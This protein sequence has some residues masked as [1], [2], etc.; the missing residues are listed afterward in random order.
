MGKDKPD[1]SEDFSESTRIG[2][3]ITVA[4]IVIFLIAAIA[5]CLVRI[6][7]MDKVSPHVRESMT[8]LDSGF[9]P[10][11][12]GFHNKNFSQILESRSNCIAWG[13]NLGDACD[14]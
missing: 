13:E 1:I 6:P 2:I 5:L 8:V 3:G 14:I 10:V 4:L 11:D 7:L 9:H 12:S